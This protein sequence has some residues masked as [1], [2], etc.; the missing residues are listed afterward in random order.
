MNGDPF[1]LNNLQPAGE[2]LVELLAQQKKPGDKPA[3]RRPRRTLRTDKFVM[4]PYPRMLKVGGILAVLVELAHLK[5][6]KKSSVV[7][8][9]N[10]NLR[11]AGVTRWA[12]NRALHDLEKAG[13]VRVTWRK[14]SSPL[15]EILWG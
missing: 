3:A 4:L 5:F 12:K 7:L 1:D 2:Q 8:L 14:K 9:T 11:A 13:M 6:K 10:K 15:V